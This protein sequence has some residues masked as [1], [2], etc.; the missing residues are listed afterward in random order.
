PCL[1]GVRV[2]VV[3][4]AA[5]SRE[6][7]AEILRCCGADATVAASAGEALEVV[8]IRPPNVILADIEMPGEDGYSLLRKVR[9][10]PC[11]VPVAALTAYASE[12]D[13]ANVLGAGFTTHV[14]KPFVPLDL[15]KI[16]ARLAESG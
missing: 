9:A 7:A 15:A 2:L 8:K 1:K 13:R 14:P 6:V 5:D 16:V 4:D 10:L 3:D 12:E 11:A